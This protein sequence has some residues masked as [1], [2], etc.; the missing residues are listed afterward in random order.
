[1]QIV[2]FVYLSFNTVD[3]TGK[4]IFEMKVFSTNA[5]ISVGVTQYKSE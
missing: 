4:K 2:L 1:M 5:K 3:R